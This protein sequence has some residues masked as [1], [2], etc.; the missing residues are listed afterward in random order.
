MIQR[1]AS[2]GAEMAWSWVRVSTGTSQKLRDCIG[3]DSSAGKFESCV[4]KI[5]EDRGGTVHPRDVMFHPNGKWARVRFEWE[6]YEQRLGIILDLEAEK[7]EDLV[8]AGEIDTLR[9]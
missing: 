1:T 9:G 3:N 6:T 8:E 5:V 4:R 2:K 7:V